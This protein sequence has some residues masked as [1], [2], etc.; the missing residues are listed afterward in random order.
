MSWHTSG[1]WHVHVESGKLGRRF[2]VRA[3]PQP[4]APA[5]LV[6][7]VSAGECKSGEPVE[8]NARLIAAAPELL[9]LLQFAVHKCEDDDEVWLGREWVK[10]ARA[11]LAKVAARSPGASDAADAETKP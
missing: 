1:P 6:A 7:R 3:A 8:A 10:Q 11:V 4:R 9:E 2:Q 5:A